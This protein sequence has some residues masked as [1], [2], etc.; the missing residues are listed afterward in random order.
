MIKLVSIIL[1]LIFILGMWIDYKQNRDI[2]SPT[3]IVSFMFIIS[4]V[5][6]IWIVSS[7]ETELSQ[8]VINH[9]SYKNLNISII[10]LSIIVVIAYI[11]NILGI[12]SRLVLNKNSY[13]TI[14]NNNQDKRLKISYIVFMIIGVFGFSFT[15][16]KNGGIANFLSNVIRRASMLRGL[17]MFMGLM[18]FS[19][20]AIYILICRLKK[21]NSIAGKL[22]LLV[23]IVFVFLMWTTLGGRTPGMYLIVYSIV[24]WNYNIKPIKILNV[25]MLVVALL[26]AIYILVVPIFRV[27]NSVKYYISNPKEIINDAFDD[28]KGI[29]KELSKVDQTMFV[30]NYF[31]PN[32]LWLG[33]SFK[34]LLVAGIPSSL[35]KDKP[36]VDDGV[37]IWNLINNNDV[38]PPTP[39]NQ[40]INSS[41]PVGTLGIMYA[42]FW[43][44]GVIIGMY[45][46]GMIQRNAYLLM[47]KSEFS[48]ISMLIYTSIIFGLEIT[49]QAIF[50]TIYDLILMLLMVHLTIGI[51]IKKYKD[52]VNI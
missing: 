13:I 35:Y 43:I 38:K 32:N 5:P 7:S 22:F 45:I 15:M 47:K 17:N 19:N 23:N 39:Y 30:V 49:N 33:A 1:L 28:S 4:F 14:S 16:Y 40:M 12:K 31:N 52:E 42:N 8:Y 44:P 37:Y 46:L 21:H 41:W 29:I 2:F 11:F 25:K 24:F 27:E 20:I 48:F 50:S 18:I 26:C 10:N 34:D 9:S 6:H 51:K 3:L 36:P